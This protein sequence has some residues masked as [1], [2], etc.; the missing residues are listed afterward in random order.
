VTERTPKILDV[1]MPGLDGYAV[2][3]RLRANDDTA[4]F[5]VIMV[6]TRR[7]GL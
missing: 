7:S 2:C 4:M 1:M 5:P 3:T 6:T